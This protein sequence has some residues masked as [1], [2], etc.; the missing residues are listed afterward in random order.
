M[1]DT[2]DISMEVMERTDRKTL[3]DALDREY[4]WIIV[5][6]NEVW[7]IEKHSFMTIGDRLY[8]TLKKEMKR[9][10]PQL[11][12]INDLARKNR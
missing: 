11:V 10:Y 1:T 12:Y 6:D 3:Y 7:W 9:L 5:S 4:F 8:K 2:K